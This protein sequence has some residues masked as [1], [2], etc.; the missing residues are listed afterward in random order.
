MTD[1]AHR[2]EELT[3]EALEPAAPA[4]HPSAIH[5]R[6][7]EL[8]DLV[9]GTTDQLAELRDA[10]VEHEGEVRIVKRAI[11]ATLVARLDAE[12]VRS[13]TVG[14]WKL[15][16]PSALKTSWQGAEL[17]KRLRALVREGVLTDLAVSRAV[18]REV[19]Y[20]TSHAELVKL[21][22]HADERVRDA[23][24]AGKQVTPVEAHERRVT[25]KPLRQGDA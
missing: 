14:R 18:R 8:I 21:E 16:A 9:D 2:P 10:L 15:T 25:V 19:A 13:A 4:P 7:G 20:A 3:G 6:T 17:H 5:P 12:N 11:D 24:T 23:I 22:R 1:L